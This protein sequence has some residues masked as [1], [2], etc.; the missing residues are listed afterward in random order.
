LAD[1]KEQHAARAA[2]ADR[3]SRSTPGTGHPVAPSGDSLAWP[4]LAGVDLATPDRI[5]TRLEEER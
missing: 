3:P 2:R 1:Q 5:V 4:L